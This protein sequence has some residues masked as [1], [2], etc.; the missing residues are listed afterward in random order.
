MAK[1]L[2]L[3][4]GC[5]CSRHLRGVLPVQRVLPRLQHC[6][7]HHTIGFHS[8]CR[9]AQPVQLLSARVHFLGLAPCLFLAKPPS[10]ISRRVGMRSTTLTLP[11][12]TTVRPAFGGFFLAEQF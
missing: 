1:Q 9:G 6:T 12:L 7:Q 10:W 2:A 3:H 5:L 11:P 8:L 4:A